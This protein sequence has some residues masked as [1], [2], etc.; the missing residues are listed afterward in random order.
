MH[1]RGIYDDGL[2]YGSMNFYKERKAINISAKLSMSVIK[3][4][5]E[6]VYWRKGKKWKEGVD[7]SGTLIVK[8]ISGKYTSLRV[9]HRS[10]VQFLDKLDD[11]DQKFWSIVTQVQK[12]LY[13]QNNLPMAILPR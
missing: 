9:V 11:I 10:Y 2:C 12:E 6:F 1:I 5:V 3:D 8:P 4:I 13:D 7:C